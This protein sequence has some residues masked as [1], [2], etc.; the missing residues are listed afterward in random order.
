[1]AS[2]RV[3]MH[4]ETTVCVEQSTLAGRERADVDRFHWRSPSP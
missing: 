1:M 3:M 4:I 2:W